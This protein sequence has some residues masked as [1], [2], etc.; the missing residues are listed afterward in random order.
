MDGEGWIGVYKINRSK[1]RIGYEFVPRIGVCLTKGAW[2]LDELKEKYGGYLM[3]RRRKELNWRDVTVLQIRGADG[4]V[5]LRDILPYLKIKKRQAE[6]FIEFIELQGERG[7]DALYPDVKRRQIEIYNELRLLNAK[8]Y[9]TPDLLDVAVPVGVRRYVRFDVEEV[10]RLYWDE[11]MSMVA[12]AERF[13]VGFSAVRGFFK[14]HGVPIRSRSD[15]ARLG[16]EQS[17]KVRLFASADELRRAYVEE[18]KSLRAVGREFGVSHVQ[19]LKAMR[20][21]EIPRR[22]RF[23]ALRKAFQKQE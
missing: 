8:G 3:I 11:S 1:H 21:Y 9:S 23:G 10:R 20:K 6:L 22:E 5:F 4:V 2:I 15:Y 7:M 14:L 13:G 19:V 17:D 12:I 16:A 18:G